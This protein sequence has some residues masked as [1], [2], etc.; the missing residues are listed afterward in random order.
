MR[1]DRGY[2]KIEQVDS[3]NEIKTLILY[4]KPSLD[5][6]DSLQ[7][8]DIRLCAYVALKVKLNLTG[9]QNGWRRTS[10]M[11]GK[12]LAISSETEAHK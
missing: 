10:K 6:W 1:K 3:T 12:P 11:L 2:K 5:V 7:S 8:L 4:F 9:A